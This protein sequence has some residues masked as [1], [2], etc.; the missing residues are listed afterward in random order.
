MENLK[1]KIADITELDEINQLYRLV[2]KTTPTWD[3]N[4]KY[5]DIEMI[6]EDIKNNALFCLKYENKIIGVSFIGDRYNP[7]FV[8]NWKDISIKKPARFAKICI[9]PEYQGKGLGRYL[10][11][12]ILKTIK[13]RGYDGI[14]V[15]VAQDNIAAIKLYSS[16]GFKNC[17]EY[18][19]NDILWFAFE[20]N[21]TKEKLYEKI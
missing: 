4:D 5:P 14:R 20:L 17:G 21:L 10:A 13:E 8:K 16:L 19:E 18:E 12:C 15:I 1:Y 2:I 7:D 11:E 9:H 6:K 3:W